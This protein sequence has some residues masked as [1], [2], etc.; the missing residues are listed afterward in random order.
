MKQNKIVIAIAG[1]VGLLSI[2]ALPYMSVEGFSMKFWQFRQIPA[3]LS[4]G[5]LNGPHQVYVAL[6]GILVPL[7]LALIAIATKQLQRWQAV[8]SSLGFLVAFAAEGVHKGLLGDHHVGTAI[9]GKLLFL[10]VA[11][12]FVVSIIGTVK[13]EPASR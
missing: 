10:S 3:S 7:L 1:L 5:L 8:L 13:P 2:F 11:I 6:I 4:T 9:G 12:G